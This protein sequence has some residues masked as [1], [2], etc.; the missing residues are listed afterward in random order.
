MW[1]TDRRGAG[2]GALAGLEVRG[3]LALATGA[4]VGTIYGVQGLAPAMPGIQSHLGL[5]D[6]APGLLAA[7]YMLPAVLFALPFGYLADTIGRRRVF[8]A[9]AL[10]WS[11]AGLAQA[12]AGSLGMLLALRFLQGVG[13][14]ALMPLSVTLI[15]DAVRGLAQTRAQASRQVL[16]TLGEFVLPLI[17]AALAAISWNAPLAA[18][19]ALLPLAVGG[20]V[21]LDD[22]PHATASLRGYAGEL[23]AAVRMDG[24]PALLAAGF[25][26]MWCK[27]A[28]TIYVPVVLVQ[29]RGATPVQA[30]AVISISALVA[31]GA[32]TQVVRLLRRAAASRLLIAAITLAGAGMVALAVAPTWKAALAIGVVYGVGDG[33]LMVLQNTMV[34]EAAPGT[35]RA[36]LMAANGTL[37]NAGKLLAPLTI[38]VL[39]LV[40]SPALA[41]VAVGILA[42]LA[43]PWLRSLSRLDP[44]VAAAMAPA[45][46]ATGRGLSPIPERSA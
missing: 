26:R 13:F 7:A 10:L 27:F 12:W 40:I 46:A 8:V 41:L 4:A 43:L 11:L 32:S 42:W 44:L 18:Q 9:T 25:L 3:R 6:S 16:M 24:M 34:V 31:A 37:R 23:V 30:A 1:R 14:G 22:R 35:V 29:A 5:G 28:V 33:L 20:A 39:I 17:G 19:A 15:G 36:G 21:L 38:G 2:D 45:R